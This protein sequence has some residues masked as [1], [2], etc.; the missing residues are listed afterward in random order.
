MEPAQQR[1]SAL[2]TRRTPALSPPEL[3]GRWGELHVIA[4]LLDQGWVLGAALVVRGDPGIGKSALL[5]AARREAR[6]RVS[7]CLPR[8]VCSRRPSCPSR[9]APAAA[10]GAGLGAGPAARAAGGV[11]IRVRPVRG[12]L[13]RAVPHRARRGEPARPAVPG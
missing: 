10:T 1:R 11:A 2:S 8:W 9:A 5:G 13:A 4:E 12:S 3:I 7:G 6:A